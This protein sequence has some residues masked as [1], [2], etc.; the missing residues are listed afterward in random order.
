MT[1]MEILMACVGFLLCTGI[2]TVVCL[3]IMLVIWWTFK[4]DINVEINV[5]EWEKER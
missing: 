4:T 3:L 5:N 2:F 1:T